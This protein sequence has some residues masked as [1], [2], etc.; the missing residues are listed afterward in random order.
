ME[1]STTR[2]DRIVTYVGGIPIEFDV[3]NLNNILG[4][5]NARHRIYTS[6]KALS[7]DSFAHCEG[8]H[9]IFRRWDLTSDICALSFLSQLLPL[10]IRILHIILQHIITPRKGH[11]DE[12]TRLDVGLLDSLFT[13]RPINL[14]YVI[15]RRM[16]STP[17]VN[18]CLLPYDSI[19]SKILRH[20]Q[21]PFWDVVYKETKLIDSEAMTSI[22]F[23]R[24]NDE[25]LKTSNS[26]NRDTLVALEDD[27][28]LNDV[29]PPDQL[30]PVSKNN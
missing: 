12:I 16:L 10:Q 1:I 26:K 6:Q 2:L 20:F 21:V 24:K 25:W 4:I 7:F 3:E 30:E 9:N 29:Y 19:I 28:M 23:S 27:R 14:R 22:G 15:L 5:P 17:S 8:V 18:H 13:G 11:S